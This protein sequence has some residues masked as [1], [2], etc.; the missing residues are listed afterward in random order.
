MMATGRTILVMTSLASLVVCSPLHKEPV[1]RETARSHVVEAPSQLD[2]SNHQGQSKHHSVQ[3]NLHKDQ[4]SQS[5]DQPQVH[6]LVQHS[7]KHQFSYLDRPSQEDPTL[8]D[9]NG[10]EVHPEKKGRKVSKKGRKSN[11]DLLHHVGM[12]KLRSPSVNHHRKRLASQSR[13]T[14]SQKSSSDSKMFVIKLPPNP[15]YYAHHNLKGYDVVEPQH[16]SVNK[17]PVNFN[18]NGK[19]SRVYHWNI[20][21][22]KKMVARKAGSAGKSAILADSDIF[23]IDKQATWNETD[24]EK[25]LYRKAVFYGPK[26]QSKHTFRKYYAGNGKP[27]SFYVMEKNKSPSSIYRLLP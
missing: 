4:H 16:N 20:P 21:V 17:V 6:H 27:H 11:E 24:D 7:Q 15:Y 10:N 22:L 18:T 13:K 3:P 23:N 1:K 26:K 5:L 12:T 9:K 19:P 8:N 2:A 25:T 14:H